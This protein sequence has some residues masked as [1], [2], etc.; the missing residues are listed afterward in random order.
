[1]F[2]LVLLMQVGII[3]LFCLPHLPEDFEPALAQAA[4]STGV[5]LASLAMSA[6][7]S[8]RPQAILAAQINPK[9]DGLTKVEIAR[10]TNRDI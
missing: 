8:L 10:A 6:V 4:Q 9:M 1:M 7:I 3:R 5:T 2:D